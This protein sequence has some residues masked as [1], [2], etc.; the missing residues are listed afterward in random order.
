MAPNADP[1]PT[2]INSNPGAAP[3]IPQGTPR[4]DP[5]PPMEPG[6]LDN[7]EVPGKDY[8]PARKPFPDHLPDPGISHE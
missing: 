6:V 1:H 3:H 2:P 7:E 8:P 5:A 4:P